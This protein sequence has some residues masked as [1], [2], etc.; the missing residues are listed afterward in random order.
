MPELTQSG[1]KD[2]IS[3]DRTWSTT[4]W[5]CFQRK[6]PAYNKQELDDQAR[7]MDSPKES[8]NDN[9]SR[10]PERKSTLSNWSWSRRITTVCLIATTAVALISSHLNNQEVLHARNS[11]RQYPGRHQHQQN[12]TFRNWTEQVQEAG[13]GAQL[14]PKPSTQEKSELKGKFLEEKEQITTLNP[15]I[16]SRENR[17]IE[18][19]E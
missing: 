16:T 10:L 11:K 8:Q 4:V 19:Q 6:F 17:Q 12:Q 2:G 14:I 1:R 7:K 3:R 15:T 9:Q 18:K 5:A 13:I